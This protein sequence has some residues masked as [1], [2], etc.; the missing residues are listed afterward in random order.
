MGA[1]NDGKS[2]LPCPSAEVGLNASSPV[3]L[4]DGDG[5]SS[6]EGLS[7]LRDLGAVV[8]GAPM[9]GILI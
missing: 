8:E 7:L 5:W 9:V 6:S 4:E 2:P 3:W 1:V